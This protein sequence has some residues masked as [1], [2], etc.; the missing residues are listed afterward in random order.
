MKKIIVCSMLLLLLIPGLTQSS[1]PIKRPMIYGGPGIGLDYGGL[2]VKIEY[3]PVKWLGLF[4]GAGY[5]FNGLGTNGGLS[6]K[7]FPDYS[8]TPVLMVMYGYNAVMKVKDALNNTEIFSETYYGF[9]A[10]AGYDFLVGKNR[11]KISIALV[12]P[13]R[14]N[15]FN[16]QYNDF[17]E[18]G[19]RFSSG[20]PAV[21]FSAGFSFAGYGRQ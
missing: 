3:L 16:E 8:S 19:Y 5:N 11:N 6:F 15:D 4:G 7:G 14:S 1:K 17:K 20:K 2:G 18:A 13:F 12:V 9:S 21:L 10:G